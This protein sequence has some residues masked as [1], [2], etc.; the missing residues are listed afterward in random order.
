MEEM[1]TA[2]IEA[3]E[4]LV[5]EKKKR[6]QGL[7]IFRAEE[8]LDELKRFWETYSLVKKHKE[9]EMPATGIDIE[10]NAISTFESQYPWDLYKWITS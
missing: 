6:G 1:L 10:N 9:I 4:R 7:D 5:E 2:R 3:T 8:R